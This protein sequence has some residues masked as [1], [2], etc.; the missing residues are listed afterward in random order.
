MSYPWLKKL[1]L[2]H[3]SR[4][5]LKGCSRKFE[6]RKFYQHAS[7]DRSVPA[8][9]G[10]ALHH[11]YQ[12]FLKTGDEDH[13]L[14]EMMLQYPIDLSSDE[15]DKRSLE[16]CYATMMALMYSKNID[17]YELINIKCLDGKE[18]PAI[19]VPFEIFLPGIYLDD[20]N[21]KIPISYIGY[22]DTI[23]WSKIEQEFET[24]DIKSHRRNLNDLTALYKWDE[25]VLP[26]ALILEWLTKSKINSLKVTYLAAYVDLI[27]P[28]ITPYTYLK[29]QRD[30]LDWA[31]GLMVDIKNLQEFYRLAWFPRD[32]AKNEECLAWNYP[33]K[34]FNNVCESRNYKAIQNHL[35]SGDK[36]YVDDFKPWITME[37]E[38]V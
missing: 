24:I 35:L 18:R 22:I 20:K 34:F 9:V 10:K 14:F 27:N 23:V 30:I 17:H 5:T 36:P 16:A 26:Y 2:S 13:S 12:E 6:L 19:E 3:S 28:I 15:D 7:Q 33:C 25:Q 21:K 37:L 4:K 1:R 38:L 8:D 32:G 29:G 11:G 31:N